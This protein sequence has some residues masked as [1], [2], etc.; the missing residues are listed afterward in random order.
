MPPPSLR[1]SAGSEFR[2]NATWRTTLPSGTAT[3]CAMVRI[4]LPERLLTTDKLRERERGCVGERKPID[5][6]GFFPAGKPSY[7]GSCVSEN[8]PRLCS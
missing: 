8:P 4:V 2:T 6:R 5:K 1:R 3:M 7:G